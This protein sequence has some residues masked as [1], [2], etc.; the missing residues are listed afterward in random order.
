MGQHQRLGVGRREG[1]RL[2]QRPGRRGAARRQ[3]AE[4]ARQGRHDRVTVE[5]AKHVDFDRALREERFPDP[6]EA[7]GRRLAHGFRVG[8]L[9]ARIA[10]VQQPFEIAV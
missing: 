10:A 7:F 6:L 9:E 5:I 1:A 2:G 3:R 8:R 4:R